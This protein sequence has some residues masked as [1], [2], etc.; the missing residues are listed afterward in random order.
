MQPTQR[1]ATLI[2]TMIGLLLGLFAVLSVMLL[3]KT[4]VSQAVTTRANTS[5]DGQ[6]AS[7]LM[8]TQLEVQRAGFGLEAASSCLDITGPP[9]VQV[10]GP[11]GTANIDVVLLSGATLI[12]AKL[13][14]TAL[15]IPPASASASASAVSGNAVIWRSV[16]AAA[17]SQ[18]AGLIAVGGG[19]KLLP[20]V[21]CADATA[22]ASRTW[23]ET[24][25]QD[26]DSAGTLSKARK[27]MTF[28]AGMMTSCA[29]FGRSTAAPGLEL[30]TTAG[31]SMDNIT[32]SVTS[33]IPNICR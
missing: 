26:V 10:A 15:T 18:C 25:V 9:A 14:G 2:S 16:N 7:A 1:G 19:L 28:S 8:V 20:T 29:P 32:S 3:Y 23:T 21:A 17:V 12:N 31:Q 24:S 4:Q 11:S 5:L 22:W 6:V 27:A 33:C 13:A 30:T